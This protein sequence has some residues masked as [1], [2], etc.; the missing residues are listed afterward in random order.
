MAS[1]E[2]EELK[3]LV[4]ASR[5]SSNTSVVAFGSLARLEW[6]SGSDVDWTLLIDGPSDM[7]HFDDSKAVARILSE[8]DYNEPGPTGTFGSLSISHEMVH[9]IGGLEDSNENLTR[10]IL[11]LLESVPL[12]DSTTHNRVVNAILE[13]YIKGDPPASTPKKFYCP[14]FLFNDIARFWRTMA[15]DY[16]TKKWQ[17]DN[18]GWALRNIKFRMSRKLLFVKGILMCFLCDPAFA[19]TPIDKDCVESELIAKCKKHASTSAIDLLC[20]VLVQYAREDKARSIISA[21]DTFLSVLNDVKKREELKSLPFE[22]E[23]EGVY[24]EMRKTSKQFRD[25]I[26]DLFFESNPDLTRLTKRYGAF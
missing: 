12:S 24:A 22:Q 25:G 11:L 10:R 14:L 15:V 6:T 17:R 21:Y 16:A 5:P 3:K 20:S 8:N 26:L 18:A 1:K 4:E 7:C 23:A 9:Y 19:G 2:F 13:K